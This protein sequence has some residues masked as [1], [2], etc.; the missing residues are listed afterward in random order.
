VSGV[1]I[2]I[3]FTADSPQTAD[4]QVQALAERC[5]T[6]QQEPGCLQ[7]EAFR[8]VLRPETWALVEHWASEEA[9]DEHR[10][11]MTPREP[12][13]GVSRQREIYSHQEA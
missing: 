6:T 2:L 13:A 1:R 3:Q 7:F 5:R 9:L 10:K 8:S 12:T 4:A 11:R